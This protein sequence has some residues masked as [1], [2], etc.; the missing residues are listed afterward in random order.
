MDIQDRPRQTKAVDHPHKTNTTRKRHTV[1]RTT[2]THLHRTRDEDRLLNS[3]KILAIDRWAGEMA[4]HQTNNGD[5]VDRDRQV[6]CA[7]LG[8]LT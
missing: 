2:K 6:C 7:I 1:T 4:P 5:E 8:R 3:D